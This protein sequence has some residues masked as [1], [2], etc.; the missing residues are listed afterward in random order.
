[1][2][3]SSG[4]EPVRS[5]FVIVYEDGRL[6]ACNNQLSDIRDVQLLKVWLPRRN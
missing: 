4:H 2:V 5:T 1:M 6:L 3:V